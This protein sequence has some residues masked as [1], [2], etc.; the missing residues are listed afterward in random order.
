MP[1]INNN[2]LVYLKAHLIKHFHMSKAKNLS[3]LGA[4][5]D[6]LFNLDCDNVLNECIMSY[7]EIWDKYPNTII[8]GYSGIK[9]DG[10]YGKIGVP[11]KV[12]QY[13]GGYDE[14]FMGVGYDDLDFLN[15]CR[16]LNL[17]YYNM[18]LHSLAIKNSKEDS[19]KCID[20]QNLTYQQI[21]HI[22]RQISERKLNIAN[23][24]R[25][26][27]RQKQKVTINFKQE[28]FI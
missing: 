5:G 16:K 22:N 9:N 2:I 8:H 19:M 15:R 18:R 26:T 7:R 10:T 20:S 27:G 6:F 25:N 13:L 28:T 3:H 11:K 23:I 17:N 14:D 21:Y 24:I 4:N 12:F 1:E